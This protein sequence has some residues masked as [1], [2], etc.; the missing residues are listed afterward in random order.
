MSDVNAL[1]GV[2]VKVYVSVRTP[3]ALK[4][5]RVR[6][7]A[8]GPVTSPCRASIEQPKYNDFEEDACAGGLRCW[9]SWEAV[10]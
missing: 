2:K 6:A 9:R 5:Y 8:N 4:P 1:S 7:H 10:R 3:W